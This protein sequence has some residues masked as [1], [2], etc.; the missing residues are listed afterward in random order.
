MSKSNP[1][2]MIL[3]PFTTT[4]HVPVDGLLIWG[5]I[6]IREDHQVQHATLSFNLK[7]RAFHASSDA[8]NKY[9][10]SPPHDI[11]TT[12][13][14]RIRGQLRVTT[15][16]HRGDEDL[17]G[18]NGGMFLGGKMP[19]PISGRMRDLLKALLKPEDIAMV[20]KLA[21]EAIK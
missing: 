21:I 15:K 11:Q 4:P 1:P 2:R 19:Q 6:T 12:P 13:P 10:V 17:T 18:Q 16:Y 9:Y 7:T 3:G 20:T 14:R 8:N 5:F